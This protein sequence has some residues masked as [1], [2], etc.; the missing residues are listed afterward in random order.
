M[1]ERVPPT[2]GDERLDDTLLSGDPIAREARRFVDRALEWESIWRAR[3][4]QDA[5]F[6][7]G[8]PDNGYQW[9]GEIYNSRIR[10][11]KPCLTINLIR[12]HN[13]IISNT[14][15]K[16]KSTVKFIGL[17]NGATQESA[18]VVRDLHRHVE[19]QSMAQEVY[20]N[21]RDWQVKIGRGW[22]RWATEYAEGTFDQEIYILPV[23]DPLSVVPDPDAKQKS[24]LDMTKALIFDDV[25]REEFYETY[26]EL[27]HVNLGEQPLGM[28]P[29]YTNWLGQHKVRVA[30]YFRKVRSQRELMSFVHQGRRLTMHR[31]KIEQVL[32]SE[33][34]KRRVLAD[35]QTMFRM[36]WLDEVEWHLIV[37]VK[38]IDSTIWPGRYIP[39]VP[40]KGEESVTD[41]VYD[42]PGHTRHMKDAQRMF[43]Y[44][45]SGQVEFV[46]GQTKTPWL[47]AKEAI[48]ELEEDWATANVENKS[49]LVWNYKSDES[50]SEVPIP[51]PKRI[52]PPVS[53]PAYQEGIQ[54][55]L[56]QIQLASGQGERMMGQPGNERTGAAINGVR[57]QGDIATFQWQ[58]N[59]ETALVT[60]GKIFIDLFPRVY[61]TK[62]VK[63]ILADDGT[64]YEIVMDP[65]A[66]RAF[67]QEQARDGKVIRRIFNPLLGR[68]DIAAQAGP[69]FG[70]K[71]LETVEALS[72]IITQAPQLMQ[73]IGDL[74]VKNMPFD[75]AQEA[76]LRLKRLVPPQALGQGPSLAEQQMQAQLVALGAALKKALEA[77]AKEKLRLVG[78]DQLRDIEAYKAETDRMK[79]LADQLP[80][81]PEGLRKIIEQLV[82]DS[83][84]TNVEETA[85]GAEAE[86][87]KDNP[88]HPVPGAR[89]APDGNWYVEN[90][91]QPGTHL[92]IRL[93]GAPPSANP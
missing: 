55:A 92:L 79:A 2:P 52:D 18:N 11:S 41:G 78:K 15:R 51:E 69:D 58:D 20:T 76:A 27:R 25:P 40:V 75:D 59:Y 87:Q 73:V 82:Q 86:E 8:D 37:G 81:D 19:W 88:V 33:G 62:R 6:A 4:L 35:P 16:N 22:W 70:S 21:A 7:V 17:G 84:E 64:D 42:S 89:M 71:R 54:T 13:G 26:P 66:Q 1:N 65:G 57:E 3:A 39:L 56:T 32:Q 12:Q 93:R 60:S 48:E 29:T 31:E 24:G 61:D 28:G 67:L 38:S 9:P 47:V 63:M 90:P 72:V 43:N 91:A 50:G 23:L 44:N 34:A 49:V 80:L 46:A 53:S 74:L 36:E 85:R 68:Y 83:L 30:E 10:R 14:A 45:A 77:N 5:K